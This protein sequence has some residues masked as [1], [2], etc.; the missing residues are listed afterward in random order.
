MSTINRLY[1]DDGYP[2]VFEDPGSG[3]QNNHNPLNLAR[4]S[5]IQITG[6]HSS[7]TKKTDTDGDLDADVTNRPNA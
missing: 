6:F 5:A 1:D 2:A 7:H 4:I 3:L